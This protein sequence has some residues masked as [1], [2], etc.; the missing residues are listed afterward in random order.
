MSSGI[1]PT[2]TNRMHITEENI[3]KL[4]NSEE[5]R[6]ALQ[7]TGL[8]GK[9]LGE[10]FDWIGYRTIWNDEGSEIIGLDANDDEASMY[11]SEF[12]IAIAPY[13]E[14]GSYLEY[15]SSNDD[16]RTVFKD[17]KCEEIMPTIIWENGDYGLCPDVSV[18][19]QAQAELILATVGEKNIR[20]HGSSFFGNELDPKEQLERIANDGNLL[21]VKISDM[22]K[23]SI[24]SHGEEM[25]IDNIPEEHRGDMELSSLFT[26][27]NGYAYFMEDTL[28]AFYEEKMTPNKNKDV[29]DEKKIDDIMEGFTMS[30]E[31]HDRSWTL[32]VHD[33]GSKYPTLISDLEKELIQVFNWEDFAEENKEL[34][35][36][37]K[38]ILFG[39]PFDYG[40]STTKD[41]GEILFAE[42]RRFL[43]KEGGVLNHKPEIAQATTTT[44]S[45]KME[46]P[47]IKK[48][49]KVEIK[50]KIDIVQ[51]TIAKISAKKEQNKN[52]GTSS[53]SPKQ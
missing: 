24:N 13:V 35:E 34:A 15:E 26:A 4:E 39:K 6:K 14:D 19:N 5:V 1:Y 16:F 43:H 44:L 21:G 7:N 51:E 42:Y 50:P 47:N 12:L 22:V 32:A 25:I 45:M 18:Y 20:M 53:P 9:T 29:T 37:D 23:N 27:I 52:K 48:E 49:V 11:F 40:K 10:M 17:G 3:E 28:T 2:D 36:E 30:S 31:S 8:G 38:F 41:I 46:Q 33:S